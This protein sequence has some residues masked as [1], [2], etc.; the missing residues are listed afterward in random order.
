MDMNYRGDALIC[1]D[2]SPVSG[3]LPAREVR[4]YMSGKK[5]Q[6]HEAKLARAD[7]ESR[8]VGAV[9][10]NDKLMADVRQALLDEA[11]GKG[12]SSKSLK[13]RNAGH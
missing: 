11:T 4:N 1:Y 5:L 9:L 10:A 3:D 8:V 13:R 6:T 12:V 7:R 2:R